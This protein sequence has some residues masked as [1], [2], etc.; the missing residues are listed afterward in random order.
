MVPG[1]LR[2]HGSP[3]TALA[4]TSIPVGALVR[5]LANE[6]TA[7]RAAQRFPRDA[8]DHT[9]RSL[10]RCSRG[11]SERVEELARRLLEE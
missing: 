9:Q 11:P 4:Y 5:R 2:P 8:D 6:A 1:L 10:R 7:L 3:L